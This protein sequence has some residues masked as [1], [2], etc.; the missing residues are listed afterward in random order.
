M[1]IL[2]ALARLLTILLLLLL[3]LAGLAALVFSIDSG[4]QGL[5][6]GHLSKLLGGPGFRDT[7]GNFLGNLEATG[8]VAIVA[9]LCGLAA[10]LLGLGVLLG[11]IIP[12]RER[13]VSLRKGKEG[14]IAARRRALG[15]VGTA[16]VE[17]TRGVTAARVKVRP[18]RRTGGRMTVRAD[19][20]RPAVEKEVAGAIN[21]R[22]APL[23]SPFKLKLRVVT[24][25]GEPGA[26][27]Q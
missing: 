25:A 18:N 5:S 20:P 12:A 4:T 9:L 24:R 22:L 14:T 27:V 7:L 26:R 8:P 1:F 11:R 6:L 23:T 15:Q 10:M 16:L 17:G 21:D 2:R 19:K 13:L 3:T